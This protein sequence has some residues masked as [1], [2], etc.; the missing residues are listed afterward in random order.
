M[1]LGKALAVV[2]LWQSGRFDTLE[3]AEILTVAEADVARVLAVTADA[4]RG[5]AS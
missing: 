1:T 3:I 4:K 2:A 5:V